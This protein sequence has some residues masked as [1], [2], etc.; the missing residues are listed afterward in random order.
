M[1][2]GKL[3]PCSLDVYIAMEFGSDGDLFNLRSLPFSSSD[4]QPAV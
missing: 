4:E 3:Q 2:N 1:I